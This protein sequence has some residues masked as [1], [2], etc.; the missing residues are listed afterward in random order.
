MGDQSP[1]DVDRL[2]AIA[3]SLHHVGSIAPL[4][5]EGWPTLSDDDVQRIIDVA[6]AFNE[7]RPPDPRSQER[8]HWRAD[9][10]E[11]YRATK[12]RANIDETAFTS[13]YPRYRVFP[14]GSTLTESSARTLIL[15]T[16]AAVRT[17]LRTRKER[18]SRP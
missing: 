17:I 12:T 2:V 8:N 10:V 15:K 18:S 13:V 1:A 4:F 9:F 3:A 11:D 16:P 7:G 5:Q 6:P 14:D